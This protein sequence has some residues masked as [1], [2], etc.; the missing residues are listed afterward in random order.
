MPLVFDFDCTLTIEHTFAKRSIE[1]VQAEQDQYALA[2]NEGTKNIKRGV[3]S[4]LK[5]DEH[6]LSAVA[7]YHNNPAFVAG[8]ISTILKKELTLVETIRKTIAEGDSA[9]KTDIA[10]NVYRIEGIE[11]PFL[12][13][14]LPYTGDEFQS[15]MRILGNKNAQISA[16]RDFWLTK[17]F[18]NNTDTI[19]FYEDSRTNY[20][21][22]RSLGYINGYLVKESD[23]LTV[24]VNYK[25]GHAPSGLNNLPTSTPTS[26]AIPS[27]SPS[28]Q[29]EGT[30]SSSTGTIGMMVLGGFI[31]AV[32]AAA[33]AIAFTVLNAATL[34]IPGLVLAGAGIAA[35]LIGCG[36]FVSNMSRPTPPNTP[37]DLSMNAVNA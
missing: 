29:T 13:S 7:T 35:A 11:K 2:K 33:V 27:S 23:E 3:D 32:G 10:I 22:A 1:N 34:G 21:G 14:Y 12:I 31:A 5:H 20:N 4:V 17:G 24:L 28:H 9:N 37:S 30:H 36:I 6:D 25:A 16:I 15:A 18:I 8:T 19:D 26:V